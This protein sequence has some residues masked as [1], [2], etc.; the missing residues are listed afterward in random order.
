MTLSYWLILFSVAV[1]SNLL[2]LNISSAFDSVVAIYILVPLLLIPQILLCGVVVKFDDLQNKTASKDAVPMA[3][4]IMASRWAFEALA[5]EQ[6]KDNHYMAQFFDMEKEMAQARF[7]SEILTTELIGQ[8]DLVDG[9]TRLNKPVADISPKLLII[10]NEIKKLDAENFL[11]QFKYEE[12]LVTGKFNNEIAEAAKSH[13]NKLKELH[14]ERYQNAKAEKDKLI[15]EITKQ[16]GENFLYNL[17]MEN[18]NKSLEVLALNSDTKEF[19]RETPYGYIQKIAPIYKTPDFTYGRSHFLAS[20]K[21]LVG[22]YIDTFYFNLSIIWVMCFLL[23]IALYYNWLRKI[24]SFST[25]IKKMKKQ[26]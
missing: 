20:Q 19:F 9:W 5:V 18:H 25:Q 2:G 1:F 3:G 6:F 15:N 14:S 24:L 22:F 17:K 12:S 21:N 26:K 10:K 13:L 8:I 4:E 11:P 7:R 23:Y 16:K